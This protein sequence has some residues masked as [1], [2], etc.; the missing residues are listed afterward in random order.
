[1]GRAGAA[2]TQLTK[3]IEG[4]QGAGSGA[5]RSALLDAAL[6]GALA[7][8]AKM[9][10]GGHPRLE[11]AVVEA[12]ALASG[13]AA[14]GAGASGVAEDDAYGDDASGGEASPN[15]KSLQRKSRGGV[16]VRKRQ[17]AAVQRAE[18]DRAVVPK[19]ESSAQQSGSPRRRARAARAQQLAAVAAAAAARRSCR[20]RGWRTRA[21]GRR[22]FTS[23]CGTSAPVTS[24]ASA[25]RAS[26]SYSRTCTRT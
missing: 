6:T 16:A 24:S 4:A 21:M 15:G 19:D 9:P 1:M 23:A 26:A 8:L 18:A 17:E 11:A 7:V 22:P 20:S 2:L 12:K 25:A 10:E 14:N 13:G 5:V 3:A